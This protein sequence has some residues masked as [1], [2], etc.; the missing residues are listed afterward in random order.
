[1]SCLF[2]VAFL[3]LSFLILASSMPLPVSSSSLDG[4]SKSMELM[5]VERMKEVKLRLKLTLLRSTSPEG[6]LLIN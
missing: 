5:L 4:V 2:L 6:V 3:H 1:M